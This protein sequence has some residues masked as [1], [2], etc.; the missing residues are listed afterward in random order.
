MNNK[1]NNSVLDP[2]GKF[3]TVRYTADKK[4]GFHASI[5]TD[6][7]VVHH[8]QEPVKPIHQDPVHHIP[9]VPHE[10]PHDVGGGGDEEDEY[11]G[12]V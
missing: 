10:P 9:Y 12:Y 1:R 5:I 3:R 7:H 4:N 11:E 6:G 8:P 2:D